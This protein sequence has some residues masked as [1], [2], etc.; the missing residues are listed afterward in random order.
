MGALHNAAEK[1]LAGYDR[2]KDSR[3]YL[4]TDVDPVSLL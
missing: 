3:V 1:V 4:E 2:G